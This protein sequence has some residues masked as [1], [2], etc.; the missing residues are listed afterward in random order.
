MKKSIIALALI[1]TVSLGNS[2]ASSVQNHIPLTIQ[3]NF[4]KEYASVQVLNWEENE[5]YYAVN[6]KKGE[7]YLKAYYSIEGEKIGWTKNIGAFELPTG[8]YASIQNDYQNYWITDLFQ[9]ELNQETTY[10]LVLENA[11]EKIFLKN[12]DETWFTY[13]N[14]AKE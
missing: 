5:Y 7:Q 10:Y 3:Q 6:F 13:K 4:E 8:L 9:I 1:L 2:Y 11:D 14:T 12:E